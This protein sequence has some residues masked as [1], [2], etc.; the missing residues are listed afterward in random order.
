MQLLLAKPI[1]GYRVIYCSVIVALALLCVSFASVS[2]VAGCRKRLFDNYEYISSL[3]HESKCAKLH[4]I[5]AS[6]SPMKGN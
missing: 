2:D 3:K 5:I 1:G 6:M 4:G